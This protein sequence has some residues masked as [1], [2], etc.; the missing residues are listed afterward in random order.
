MEITI[1]EL[2]ERANENNIP[3]EIL[4]GEDALDNRIKNPRIQ[5]PGLALTGFT[6]HIHPAR[7]QIFGDTEITYLKELSAYKK[8]K[9]VNFLDEISISCLIITK[10][11]EIPSLLL[12]KACRNKIP[13]LRTTMQSSVFIREIEELL[14]ELLAE[15]VSIHGNLIDVFGVGVLILGK[16]GIGKSELALSLIMR[17]HRFVAD[18]MVEIVKKYPGVLIGRPTEML[19]HIVEIRGLGIVNIKDLFGISAIRDTKR[20]ELVIELVKWEDDTEYDRLGLEEDFYEIMGIKLPLVKL[21]VTPGRQLPVLIEVAARNYLLKIKGIDS[22]KD[23]K[24]TLDKILK[25]QQ[26]KE[27]IE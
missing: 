21:P 23:F 4:C 12:K 1:K 3:L 24:D 6:Y 13:L 15:K 18:D 19:K 11:L 27:E 8:R 10:G 14:N 7:V 5:K 16:S 25:E 22:A 26:K 9:A 17:N 20:I 2:I